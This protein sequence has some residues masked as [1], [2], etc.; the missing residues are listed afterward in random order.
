MGNFSYILYNTLVFIRWSGLI[1]I[2]ILSMAVLISEAAKSKLSPAKIL[3]V[4]ASAVLAAV[5]FW[6]LPTLVNYARTDSNIIVPDQPI[7]SY[8]R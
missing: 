5:M 4:A 1:V 3:G 2:T 7:G 8:R 6:V